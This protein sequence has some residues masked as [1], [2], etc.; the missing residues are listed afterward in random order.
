M[1]TVADYIGRQVDVLFINDLDLERDSLA[2]LALALE[3]EGGKITAGVQKLGQRWLLE[4]MTEQGS[5]RYLPARGT[6]FMTEA[7]QGSLR[8]TVDAEL[9]FRL[10]AAQAQIQ[11]LAEEDDN[12]P[13]DE[14]FGGVSLDNI[15]V[16]GDTLTLR[17][18]VFSRAGTSRQ[19][20]LPIS[21]TV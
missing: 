5:I 7:R 12:M 17:V 6:T 3:G 1:S 8:T 20:L 10:A 9:S 21:A 13:D 19:V 18:T 11:L 4:M 16:I 15:A 2:P 14:R